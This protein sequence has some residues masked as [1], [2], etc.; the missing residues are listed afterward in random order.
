MGPVVVVVVDVTV[1]NPAKLGLCENDE[2]V[3]T[4]PP[5]GTDKLLGVG[6]RNASLAVIKPENVNGKRRTMS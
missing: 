5:D 3:R 2:V 1:D 4:F 6:V